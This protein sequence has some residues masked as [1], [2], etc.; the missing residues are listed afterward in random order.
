MTV[1]KVL[2]IGGTGPTGP[3]IVQGLLERGFRV[4]ILHRGEHETAEIPAKVEHIHANPRSEETL[5]QALGART[6]DLVI[7]TYGRLRSV[8]RVM[9]ERT[10]RFISVGGFPTFRGFMNPMAFDPPGLPVPVREEAERV[11]NADESDKSFQVRCTEDLVFDLHPQATHL[12]YPFVYGPRQLLPRAWSLVRRIL[13]HRPHII[14]PEGGLT[15]ST[16]GYAENMAH[17]VLLAVDQPEVSRGRIYNCGDEQVL[18]L[19]QVVDIVARALDHR[20]RVV[21]LPWELARSARPLIMQ[22]LPTH[23][24]IDIS[25]IRTELGY[26]DRV[27]PAEALARTAHWL[28]ENPPPRGGQE[29]M[30]LQDPFDYATEDRLIAAWDAAMT[31]L[32]RIR[33]PQEPGYGL[34]YSGPPVPEPS[35]ESGR[36]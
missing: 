8:A 34:S 7:A 1:S 22:P 4:T 24:V 29:E 25:R 32:R 30:V 15:L 36:F 27:S 13:E 14:L 21:S 23:R 35:D 19:R 20:W 17:A 18:T 9:C 26:R 11:A 31:G 16:F 6:F 33:F 5:E 2:L 10:E 28:V 12:R 3:W